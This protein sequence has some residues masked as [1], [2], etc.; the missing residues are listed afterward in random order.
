[1]NDRSNTTHDVPDGLSAKRILSGLSIPV[2]VPP[3]GVETLVR[4]SPDKYL[5]QTDTQA[6]PK[7]LNANGQKDK[8]G[9][10]G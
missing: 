10:T 6:V 8:R 5:W 3:I 9:E 2:P 7:D 1:M 4:D